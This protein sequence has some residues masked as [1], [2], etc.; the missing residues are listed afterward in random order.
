MYTSILIQGKNESA[1]KDCTKAIDLNPVYVKA[2]LRR[3]KLYEALEQLDKALADYRELNKLEPSNME[4]KSA[5]MT[6]PQR[7]EEQNEKLKKEMLG[8]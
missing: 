1:L 8:K 6:L 7:I 2:M 4:V 3:A 5:L